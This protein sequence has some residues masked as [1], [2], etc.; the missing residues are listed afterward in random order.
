MARGRLVTRGRTSRRTESA[1]SKTERISPKGETIDRYSWDVLSQHRAVRLA[2][3]EALLEGRE[4]LSPHRAALHEGRA[5]IQPHRAVISL[6][7]D[8]RSA[9]AADISLLAEC[10]KH[11]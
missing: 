10:P 8:D 1:S 5:V 6:F 9:F 11:Y 7:R 3:G 2:C 4:A